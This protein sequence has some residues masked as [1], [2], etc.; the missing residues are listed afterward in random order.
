MVG[1]EDGAVKGLGNHNQQKRMGVITELLGDDK[2][3]VE[4]RYG[5]GMQEGAI[6]CG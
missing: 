5:I 4:D 1:R 3:V 6:G 2:T